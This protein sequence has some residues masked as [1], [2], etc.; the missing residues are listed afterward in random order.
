M[1]NTVCAAYRAFRNFRLRRPSAPATARRN[2]RSIATTVAGSSCW[3]TRLRNSA[4]PGRP[5][6]YQPICLRARLTPVTRAVEREH[7][8]I[9]LE[10]R[11]ELL[12]ER[13]VGPRRPAA[14][15]GHHLAEQPRPA[16]GA[17]ADHHPVGARLRERVAASSIEQMSP[18]TITGS[19]TASLTLADEAPVGRALV[20]LA[21]GAAVDGDHPRR[22]DPRRSARARAR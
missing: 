17:A 22:R 7:V 5:L 8:L 12:V 1:K 21:A 6:V 15:V 10:D 20:H 9:L 18:L 16:I 4:E 2:P 3:L 14:Q 13:R 11:R 19:A